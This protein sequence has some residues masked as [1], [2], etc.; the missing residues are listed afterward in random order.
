MSFYCFWFSL[1]HFLKN[2]AEDY[3]T[4]VSPLLTIIWMQL[5]V[6]IIFRMYEMFVT[7]AS[8]PNC[9]KW[10]PIYLL[11]HFIYYSFVSIQE[12]ASGKDDQYY[13]CS[14]CK[15]MH[16]WVIDHLIPSNFHGCRDSIDKDHTIERNGGSDWRRRYNGRIR[17]LIQL[18]V[19]I[20]MNFY[21]TSFALDLF[22]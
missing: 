6:T 14:A 2:S 11:I 8:V 18:H 5:I 20:W 15:L 3:D 17:F 1:N 22:V 9:V 10:L 12:D 13:L 7:M 4:L 21:Y 19:A 16:P